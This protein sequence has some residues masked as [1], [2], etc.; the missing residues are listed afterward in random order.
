MIQEVRRQFQEIDGL[1]E[2]RAPPNV[3]LCIAISTDASIREMII[4]GVLAVAA[5][6]FIGFL[7]N[8]EALAGM[9]VG[10]IT[11]GF[12]LAVFMSNAGGAW[13]NAKKFVEAKGLYR[14]YKKKT[15]KDP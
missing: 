10:G 11:S 15:K 13:D 7:L 6:L 3:Q 8:A 2:G 4:P 12:M 1:L 14:V 5:P 9:L